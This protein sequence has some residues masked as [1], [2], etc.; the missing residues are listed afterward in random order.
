MN[1]LKKYSLSSTDGVYEFIRRENDYF[2]S[3]TRLTVTEIGNGN[4]N[5]VYRIEDKLS[6]KSY[7]V[8]YAGEHTRISEDI[9]VSTDR[10]KIE[11]Y[12][13]MKQ[14]K[15]V[16]EYIPRIY[17]FDEKRSC[18][19]MEDCRD[20]T[21]L[22]D[23]LVKYDIFPE[24]SDQ[25][26]TYL[27]KS[28]LPTSEIIL[29][30]PEKNQ[31][32]QQF[33]NPHLCEITKTYV[34]TEPFDA[35]SEMNDIFIPN[36]EYIEKE[37]FA[38]KNLLQEIKRLKDDFFNKKQALLHGDL[39]TGSIFINST[40]IAIFDFEFAFY[41]PIGFDLGNLIANLIFAW[42]HAEADVQKTEFINWMEETVASVIDLFRF[43]FKHEFLRVSGKDSKDSEVDIDHY[44]DTIISDTASYAGVELIRRVVG[45]AHVKDITS[46]TPVD[47]RI[48]TERIAIDIAKSI[49]FKN[50]KF[51][52]GI[53]FTNLINRI[54]LLHNE[55]A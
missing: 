52:K 49:I 2:K 47:K 21:I 28:I 4:M 42:L 36:K 55:N 25:I 37:I 43:K 41:G 15:F 32:E 1:V 40:S 16:S 46:I 7:I 48:R 27:V 11:A 9:P 13:L 24:F 20:Y 19:L 17:L 23:S 39:H 3:N 31:L 33:L 34:F 50:T 22:R 26:S 53:D 45:L 10:I 12:M 14:S 18:I 35:L 38:D 5:Y 6:G 29:S 8:K 30:K 54:L 51:I 44:L